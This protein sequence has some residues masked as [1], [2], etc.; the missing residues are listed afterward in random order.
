[1]FVTFAHTVWTYI[2]LDPS[3]AKWIA[4]SVIIINADVEFEELANNC[5]VLSTI[6]KK[7][8]H[9]GGRNK[10]F[11]VSKDDFIVT[12]SNKC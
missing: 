11:N 7:M 6:N 8:D 4:F 2:L 5:P 10:L 9:N 3:F 1:M 12:E